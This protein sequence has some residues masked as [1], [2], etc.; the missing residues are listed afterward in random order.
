MADTGFGF[1]S[2]QLQGI[3]QFTNQSEDSE[4]SR[5]PPDHPVAPFAAGRHRPAPSEAAPKLHLEPH[6]LRICESGSLSRPEQLFS[7]AVPSR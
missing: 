2:L 4:K 5:L 1:R 7:C 6:P 3:P